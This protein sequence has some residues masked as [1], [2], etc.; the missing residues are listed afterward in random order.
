VIGRQR[1]AAFEAGKE[2]GPKDVFEFSTLL[3]DISRESPLVSIVGRVD[4]FSRPV[5]AD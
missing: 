5:V 2:I 3:A 1:K 4:R